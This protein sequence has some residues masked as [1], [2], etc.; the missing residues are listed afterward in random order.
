MK[1]NKRKLADKK[2]VE[3]ALEK[4]FDYAK[5]KTIP[6]PSIRDIHLYNLVEW[7][8]ERGAYIG[9]DMTQGGE[10]AVWVIAGG[11][12]VWEYIYPTYDECL[13]NACMEAVKRV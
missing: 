4:G 8:R 9:Q 3:L 13:V 11:E 10:Y 7:A 12:L 2:L 6:T 1:T 5:D